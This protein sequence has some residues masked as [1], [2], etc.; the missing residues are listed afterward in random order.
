MPGDPSSS[1]PLELTRRSFEAADSGD[2]DWMMSF[3]GPDSVFD[4][5][6][7]GL[8][9]YEGLV[10]IRAF[11]KD[12]I[13]AFEVFE[14]KLEQMDDLGSGVVMAVA[15][16][17][18]LSAGSSTPLRLR[19]AAVA[20]WENGIALAITNYPDVEHARTVAEELA[21]SRSKRLA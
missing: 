3:Y 7:W 16:Q 17:T 20:V 13:G 4:M 9:T 8:G 5:S 12:W 19:H 10:A 2:Y 18:A 11:F 1:S 21:S 15:R 14:M 6:P